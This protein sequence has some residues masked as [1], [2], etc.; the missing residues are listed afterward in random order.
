VFPTLHQLQIFLTVARRRSFARAAEELFLSPPSVTLQVQRLEQHY[1]T[2]LFDRTSQGTR[3]TATGAILYDAAETV[4]SRLRDASEAIERTRAEA[5]HRLG[6]GATML[7]GIYCLPL[8]VAIFRRRFPLAE[9]T[10]LVDTQEQVEAALLRRGIEVAMMGREAIS[11]HLR[12]EPYTREPIELLVHPS[13]PI[14]R[15]NPVPIQ[16]LAGETLLLREKGSYTRTAVD[17]AV[18]RH[19]L[20]F[21]EIVEINGIEALSRAVLENRG[22]GFGPAAFFE[23][24]RRL[25]QIATS[26]IADV[27]IQV[28]F[29]LVYRDDQALS[30]AARAFLDCCQ[31]ALV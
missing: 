11:P 18:A 23:V 29:Y 27:V 16:A 14:A 26:T 30:E 1:G 13:N 7:L 21:K 6:V 12:T 8:A 5:Q 3:L 10:I 19:G 20:R 28:P 15:L 25:G 9:V 24:E 2:R 22:I 4:C 17:E 31:G